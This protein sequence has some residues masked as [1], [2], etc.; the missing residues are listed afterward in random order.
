L[1]CEDMRLEDSNLLISLQGCSL[2]LEKD[3]LA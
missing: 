3:L 2:P 1:F